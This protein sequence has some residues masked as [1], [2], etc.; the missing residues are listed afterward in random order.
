M[1]KIQ[2]FLIYRKS[3]SDDK[4]RYER[5]DVPL[6]KGMSILEALFFIQDHHDSSLS[7]RYAC[8]GA[9]C[10]SC[11]MTI[12]KVPQLACRTQVTAVKTS[13]KPP[14]LPD[15]NFGEA[16]NWNTQEEILIEPLPNMKVITD[17]VVDMDPFWKFYNEV[18]PFFT[19]E[20]KDLAPESLQ[21][22]ED[23]R[24]IEHL[25]YCILCACCWACPVNAVNPD[26]LGPAALAKTYRFIADTRLEDESRSSIITRVSERD[27]IPACDQHFVCNRVCPKGVKPGTAIK[28]IREGWL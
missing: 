24:S 11:G 5:Y 4:P 22:P 23:A 27:A 16:P 12:D 10:G 17:L 20:W 1:T 13:R 7:F 3:P 15:F 8:R 2:K 25:V 6:R 18:K 28:E 21:T 26:Y 14:R 19:R 9:I